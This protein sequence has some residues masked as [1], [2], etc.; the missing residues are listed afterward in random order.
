MNTE[1]AFSLALSFSTPAAQD[2]QISACLTAKAARSVRPSRQYP[3]VYVR[4]R[5]SVN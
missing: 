2:V 5:A 3:L 1:G 4:Q